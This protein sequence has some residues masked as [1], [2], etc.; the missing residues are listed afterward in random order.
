VINGK[1]V[2]AVIPAR[3]GSK[4]VPG[5]NLRE[6]GGKPLIA[7]TI[8]AAKRSRYVDRVILSSEDSEIMSV[9][10]AYGCDVPFRRPDDL[11]TDDASSVDVVLHAVQTLGGEYRYV[12]LLQPTSPGRNSVDVDGAIEMCDSSGA[13]A[14][15]TVCPSSVKPSWMF[16]RDPDGKLTPLFPARSDS[17]PGVV[18][19]GAVYVVDW[20]RFVRTRKFVE[21]GTVGYLM[22]RERSI[23][24]DEEFDLQVAGLLIGGAQ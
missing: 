7:W 22:P 2:L 6:L 1:A 3:G 10:R 8:E 4:R 9:A 17:V 20:T 12:V 24:I 21:A 18:L 11:A 19:N 15:T 14:C 23:D 13:T 16:A 5:K